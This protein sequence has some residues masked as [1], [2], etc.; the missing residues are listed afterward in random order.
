MRMAQGPSTSSEA[1]HLCERS[2]FRERRKCSLYQGFHH[3]VKSVRRGTVLRGFG[4]GVSV[5]LWSG[6][7]RTS[8][9]NNIAGVRILRHASQRL[10]KVVADDPPDAVAAKRGS[11]DVIHGPLTPRRCCVIQAQGAGVFTRMALCDV[12]LVPRNMRYVEPVNGHSALRPSV[13]TRR[14]LPVHAPTMLCVGVGMASSTSHKDLDG[15]SGLICEHRRYIDLAS[16]IDLHHRCNDD[17]HV[18]DT[19]PNV[20]MFFNHPSPLTRLHLHRPHGPRKG[21]PGRCLLRACVRLKSS[22]WHRLH[23]L[24]SKSRSRTK[25]TVL[26]HTRRLPLSSSDESVPAELTSGRLP[27]ETLRWG[28]PPPS[29]KRVALTTDHVCRLHS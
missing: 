4:G 19:A 7:H 8:E 10:Q 26:S 5:G 12:C 14:P 11:A 29:A 28:A 16:A 6:R 9:C 20:Q 1:R 23:R 2:S 15:V 22:S 3:Q 25:S 21:V 27:S 18:T 24:C 17:C 13:V